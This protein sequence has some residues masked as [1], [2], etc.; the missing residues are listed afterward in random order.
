MPTL[1]RRIFID[2]LKLQGCRRRLVVHEAK[3][4]WLVLSATP[5]HAHIG[6]RAGQVRSGC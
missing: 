1:K 3:L 5:V 4:R 2:A 6:L